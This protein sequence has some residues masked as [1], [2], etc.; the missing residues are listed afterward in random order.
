[1]FSIE[2]PCADLPRQRRQ[3]VERAIK[4]RDHAIA[5]HREQR[6]GLA[7]TDDDSACAQFAGAANELNQQIERVGAHFLGGRGDIDVDIGHV[8]GDQPQPRSQ[9]RRR[10]RS[11]VASSS[12]GQRWPGKNISSTPP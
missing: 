8:D 2:K 9:S 4:V 5:R 1:M 12:A 7:G 3:L 11:W 6:I 10:L